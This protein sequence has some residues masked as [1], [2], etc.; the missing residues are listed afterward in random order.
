MLVND[1]LIVE[2]VTPRSDEPAAPGKVG[3]V[4]VTRL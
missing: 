2:I 1:E 3:E 4:V